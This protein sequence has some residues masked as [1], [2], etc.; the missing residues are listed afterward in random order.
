[1]VQVLSKLTPVLVI[2]EYYA[3]PWTDSCF[4]ASVGLYFRAVWHSI[5]MYGAVYMVGIE[6]TTYSDSIKQKL[7]ILYVNCRF[8]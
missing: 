7:S 2:C 4:D 1:M 6:F 5:R 3:H 8:Q